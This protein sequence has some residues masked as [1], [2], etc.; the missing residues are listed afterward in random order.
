MIEIYVTR[1]EEEKKVSALEWCIEWVDE[2]VDSERS[3][4]ARDE[5]AILRAEVER[6]RGGLRRIAEGNLGDEPW[7][8]SYEVIRHVAKEA[9]K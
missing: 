3:K 6:L 8:A 5:L 2:D 9:L 1:D 7:Q 4:A